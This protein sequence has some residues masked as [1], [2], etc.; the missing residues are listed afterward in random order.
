MKVTLRK[1]QST[2]SNLR[3]DVIDGEAFRL[4]SVGECF[5]VYAAPL[6]G[7]GGFR[8][9]MTSPVASL[10][11]GK[12]FTTQNSTYEMTVHSE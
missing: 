11:E 7:S 10:E 6:F 8:Y 3:T 2:H 5:C 9:V 4:P 12:G 1:V